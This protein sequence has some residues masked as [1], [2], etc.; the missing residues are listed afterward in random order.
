MPQSL[1]LRSLCL[2]PTGRTAPTPFSPVRTVHREKLRIWVSLS[3]AH[4]CH[5]KAKANSIRA[6]LVSPR[7]REPW[8]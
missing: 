8:I 3:G 6:I 1:D 5:P 4:P 7:S 2:L